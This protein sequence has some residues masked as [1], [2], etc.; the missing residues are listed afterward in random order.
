MD[1]WEIGCEHRTELGLYLVAGYDV[2][3][4]ETV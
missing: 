2:N 1:L 3:G 4:V